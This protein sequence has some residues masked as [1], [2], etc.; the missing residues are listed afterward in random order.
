MV[1]KIN[2]LENRKE[3]YKTSSNVFI[4]FKYAFSG[5]RYEF[6]IFNQLI[7]DG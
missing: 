2:S 7:R 1:K 6:G 3:S 4:S 5:I